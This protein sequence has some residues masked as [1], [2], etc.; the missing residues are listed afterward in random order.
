MSMAL[1]EA[2]GYCANCGNPLRL[3][4]RPLPG[5]VPSRVP[6]FCSEQCAR[7]FLSKD[8]LSSLR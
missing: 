7:D 1:S 5:K 4:I 6:S 2:P 8:E 3:I